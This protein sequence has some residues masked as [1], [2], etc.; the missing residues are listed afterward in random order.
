[1]SMLGNLGR[2][3]MRQ[4]NDAKTRSL[5]NS[6]LPELQRDIGWEAAPGTR[7]KARLAQV[8]FAGTR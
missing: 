7:E 6:L 2:S 5:M 1:M 8:V 3:I 4:H